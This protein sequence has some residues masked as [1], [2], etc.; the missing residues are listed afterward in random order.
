MLKE[1]K[2][3]ILDV[4]EGIIFQQVNCMN[5]M[6]SGLARSI[7]EKWPRVK[8]KYHE[9]CEGKN[10]LELLGS[11]QLVD[12]S[13]ELEIC[14]VFGQL[15]YGTKERQTDYGALK[16]AFQKFRAANTVADFYYFPL[17]FGCGLGGG[18]WPIV[19]KLID[20]HFREAIIVDF[21]E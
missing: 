5:V 10:P 6:G 4:E 9:F 8:E 16:L 1:I 18:S 20:M 13:P 7:Y 3:N 14:N 2:G 17:F 12:I 21:E 15:S 19:S 11:Y